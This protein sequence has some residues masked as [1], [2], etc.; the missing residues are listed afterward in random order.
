[1]LKNNNHFSLISS[2][3]IKLY[4]LTGIQNSKFL[5]MCEKKKIKNILYKLKLRKTILAVGGFLT[6]HVINVVSS[7]KRTR[8][9][10]TLARF[11]GARYFSQLR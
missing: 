1:M 10:T 3:K 6:I 9:R 2:Q 5:G 11:T 4:N 8:N 7:Y